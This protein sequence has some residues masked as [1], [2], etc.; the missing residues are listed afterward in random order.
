MKMGKS[1]GFFALF[2]VAVAIAVPT[3]V[4]ENTP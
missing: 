2:A 1:F 3:K 4:R